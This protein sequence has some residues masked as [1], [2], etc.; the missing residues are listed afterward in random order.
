M[1]LARSSDARVWLERFGDLDQDGALFLAVR[2]ETASTLPYTVTV[3]LA[4]WAPAA[5]LLGR[6][7]VDE[8]DVPVVVSGD[9]ATFSGNIEPQDTQIV[10]LTRP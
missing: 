4:R 2:N 7:L 3:D 9:Q 8:Q 1:T 10:R 5:V 6:E